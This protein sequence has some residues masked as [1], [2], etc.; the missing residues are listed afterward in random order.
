LEKS[1]TPDEV[2]ATAQ[3]IKFLDSDIM[4]SGI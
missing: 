4:K 3:K 2:K 1:M